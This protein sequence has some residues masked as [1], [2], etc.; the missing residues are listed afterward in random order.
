MENNSHE[1]GCDP[2]LQGCSYDTIGSVST[3]IADGFTMVAVGDLIVT[4]PL[5][6]AQ[7]PD[8][9]AILKILHEADVTF[10][11]ME[12]NIFDIRSFTGSPQAEYGGAYH[13][14]LPELGPDL[15]EMGFNLL[16][17]ANNHS[18]DW[19]VE[20]MRETCRALDQNGIVYAGVGENLAQAGAARFLETARGR[21]A[22]VSLASS[23]TPQSRAC[24]PAGEAPGRPGL[25]GL[26]VA[27]S[28]VVSPEMLEN[29]RQLRD[30]LPD[31]TRQ[32]QAPAYGAARATRR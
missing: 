1:G 6:R 14:S 17:Y 25:N 13:V 3:N 7:H 15:R 32:C 5:T 10:A 23:F 24:D 30:A 19:G 2:A 20:G 27:R 22:L 18:L 11:N 12:T 29:L 21:V 16:S 4:R 31:S 26:R 8:F 9:G 28:V